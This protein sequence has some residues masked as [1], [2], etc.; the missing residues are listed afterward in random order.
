MKEQWTTRELL[1][2]VRR[3]TLGAY[4]HQ[5]M[6]FEKLVDEFEPER[7]LDHTP[8][9]QTMLT[10]HHQSASSLK[11]HGLHITELEKNRAAREIRSDAGS[12]GH[13]EGRVGDINPVPD[14]PV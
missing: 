6:P 12:N 13:S 5:D 9:F 10:Q 4:A 7:S 8:L 1:Q 14:G 3:V 11:L 2:N